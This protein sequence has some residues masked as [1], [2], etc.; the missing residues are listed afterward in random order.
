MPACAPD[1]CAGSMPLFA[2]LA[3]RRFSRTTTC[4]TCRQP[5]WAAG[6][7]DD[8]SALAAPSALYDNL[9]MKC[10][11]KPMWVL[12]RLL[13]ATRMRRRSASLY[14]RSHAR[15]SLSLR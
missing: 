13:K 14:T 10:V 9:P 11:N 6:L 3:M 2:S 15:Y 1:A 4:G 12:A 5:F 7:A 8:D